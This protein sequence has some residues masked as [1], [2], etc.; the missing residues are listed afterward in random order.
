MQPTWIERVGADGS[1][2]APSIAGEQVGCAPPKVL[3]LNNLN[4]AGGI[5]I[6]IMIKEVAVFEF[7]TDIEVDDREGGG[8]RVVSVSYGWVGSPFE[9]VKSM[10]TEKL[11]IKPF[12]KCS[13]NPTGLTTLAVISESVPEFLYLSV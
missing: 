1:S 12:C 11:I 4:N 2:T 13:T 5:D 8:F 9:P 7:N 6:S 10:P 3:D